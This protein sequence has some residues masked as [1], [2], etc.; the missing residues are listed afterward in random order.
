MNYLISEANGKFGCRLL[1]SIIRQPVLMEYTK[2]L[3]NYKSDKKLSI[4]IYDKE[5]STYRWKNLS[6]KEQNNKALL[7]A[8]NS[9]YSTELFR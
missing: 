2:A 7:E 5:N 3:A 8:F 9:L 4:T 6:E 1:D